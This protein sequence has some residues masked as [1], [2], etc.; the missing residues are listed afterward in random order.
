MHPRISPGMIFAVAFGSA[1]GGMIRHA[2]A[3]AGSSA[4]PAAFPWPTLSV[5]V[6][7]SF[8]V[9]LLLALTGADG[10]L[11]VSATLQAALVAGFCGALT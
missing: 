10:P 7:G 1:F 6:V 5:N 9:G 2:V 4:I 8:L 3:L 11:Q